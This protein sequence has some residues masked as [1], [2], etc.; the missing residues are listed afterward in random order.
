[1]IEG[2]WVVQYSGVRGFDNGVVVLTN[3]RILGGDNGFTYIGT[4]QPSE[5]GMRAMVKVHNFDPR[6]SSVL[7]IPG[8]YTIN[9]DL[10]WQ[11]EGVLQGQGALA[12]QNAI[13]IAVKLTKHA[14]LP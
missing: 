6:V 2:L 9:L 4:Y 1:V 3:G 5:T 14:S 11:G 8:D 10:R 12:D 13:G 7:S